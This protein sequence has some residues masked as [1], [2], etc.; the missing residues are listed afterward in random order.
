L[1]ELVK[2]TS[3]AIIE[4][5]YYCPY[6]PEGTVEQYKQEHPW[7]KPQPGMLLQAAEDLGLNLD[8]C[9]MIGDA[10]RDIEAGWAA[11]TRSVL[12]QPDAKTPEGYSPPEGQRLLVAGNLVDAV[13]L[14]AQHP[15]AERGDD[16]QQQNIIR[17]MKGA[18]TQFG[19]ELPDAPG[20]EAQPPGTAKLS[21]AIEK[22][23]EGPTTSTAPKDFKQ[24]RPFKPWDIQP[25]VV[26]ASAPEPETELAPE[27]TPESASET[28]LEP[29]PESK[30]E[31]TPESEQVSQPS[32]P[33][34][35]P[36]VEEASPPADESA[37]QESATEPIAE[38][39]AP[40]AP[41]KKTRKKKVRKKKRPVAAGA[42]STGHDD[43]ADPTS[44]TPVMDPDAA[45]LLRQILRELKGHR[46]H[47]GDFSWMKMLAGL[48]QMLAIGCI[49]FGL[50]Y[51][52]EPAVFNQWAM[53]AVF[54]QLVVITML[55]THHHR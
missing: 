11:G 44:P 40:A 1:A 37:S 8:S 22:I 50:Y 21:A 29:S 14:I 48:A 6:H 41:V 38:T 43:V 20:S 26:P 15:Q 4:R 5:F 17:A 51:M 28:I 9:W 18:S 2:Q 52:Q 30:P 7:R 25:V 53:G 27:L 47:Y 10:L 12:I 45:N 23:H 33:V 54:S 46:A 31:L 19:A 49:A 32:L 16:L 13:R 34:A 35:E 55:I 39:E 24:R 3:G 42:E 36:A